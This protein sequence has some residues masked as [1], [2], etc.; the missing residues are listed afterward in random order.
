MMKAAIDFA[1]GV[2]IGS[3]EINPE[4]TEYLTQVGKPV[5]TYQSP[6]SYIDAYNEFYEEVLQA[7][8]VA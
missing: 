4:L 2:V 8:P 6:D 1:D 5:L 7:Q 3:P